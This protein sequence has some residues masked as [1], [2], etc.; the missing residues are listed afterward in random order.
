MLIVDQFLADKVLIIPDSF[1]QK[2]ELTS[3]KYKAR[4]QDEHGQQ[5]W[6]NTAEAEQASV[7]WSDKYGYNS[8][9]GDV[10]E[11]NSQ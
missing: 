4:N 7:R 2:A 10:R 1:V 8:G 5:E 9:S 6:V 3:L 11:W